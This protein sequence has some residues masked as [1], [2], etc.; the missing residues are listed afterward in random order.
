MGYRA[1]IFDLGGVVLDSPL[2]AI[3]RYE[4]EQGIPAGFVNRVVI[5]AGSDGAWPRLERGELLMEDFMDAFE[6]ECREAGQE[7]AVAEM[8]H[9]IAECGPRPAMLKAIGRI[10]RRGIAVAALTNNWAG[11][12]DRTREIRDHFDAFV[13]SSAVG[14]RKPDPRIYLLACESLAI[15]PAEAVFLDDIGRN[16]KIARELGMRTVKVDQPE[17]ALDTLSNLLGFPLR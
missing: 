6:A 13:E 8:M 15:E 4:R 14:L 7:I 10:R 11:E 9:H 1:V 2:H 17:E 12:E 5:E 16:L 3:A